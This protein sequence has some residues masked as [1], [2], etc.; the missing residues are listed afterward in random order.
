MVQH[1]LMD[2]LILL[3]PKCKHDTNAYSRQMTFIH[4]MS[5]LSVGGMA[6]WDKYFE[7][8][9]LG[10]VWLCDKST[11]YNGIPEQ[12]IYILL[13]S[14]LSWG[15]PKPETTLSNNLFI[16]LKKATF[17]LLVTLFPTYNTKCFQSVNNEWNPTNLYFSEHPYYLDTG[18]HQE[19]PILVRLY[20]L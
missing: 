15:L 10:K 20:H 12:C 4:T 5:G 17:L 1:L 11:T 8:P 3:S 14:Y 2:H 16:R 19:N 18:E 6:S 7:I 13:I 9:F